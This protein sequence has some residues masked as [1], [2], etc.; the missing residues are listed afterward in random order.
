MPFY[1][2]AGKTISFT[3]CENHISLYVGTEAIEKFASE[4]NG[5]RTKKNAIYLPYSKI[6]PSNLIEKIV[7][8][9]LT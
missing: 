6:L 5:F 7:I 8:W 2:K 4:L 3:A 1:E 9:C